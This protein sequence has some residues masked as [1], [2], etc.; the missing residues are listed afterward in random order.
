MSIHVTHGTV[1]RSVVSELIWA[2]PDELAISY[3]I[4]LTMSYLSAHFA[5]PGLVRRRLYYLNPS[6]P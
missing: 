5:L 3:L 6:K 1:G 2:T 4:L